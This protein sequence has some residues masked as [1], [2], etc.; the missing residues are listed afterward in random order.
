M[1]NEVVSHLSLM[2][3]QLHLK[4]APKVEE[5]EAED[6]GAACSTLLVRP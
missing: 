4:P 6:G 1:L 3:R 2:N 5:E